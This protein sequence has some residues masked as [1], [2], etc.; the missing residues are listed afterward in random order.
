MASTASRAC[1]YPQSHATARPIKDELAALA[2]N[3][4]VCAS[5]YLDTV[6]VMSNDSL[7]IEGCSN[8]PVFC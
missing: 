1:R 5:F 2:A 4:G 3:A 7:S 8:G 6:E